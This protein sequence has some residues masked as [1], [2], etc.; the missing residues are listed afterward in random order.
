MTRMTTAGRLIATI[1][2]VVLAAP[3]QALAQSTERSPLTV[4]I[5]TVRNAEV[6]A[7]RRS[8]LPTPRLR[9]MVVVAVGKEFRMVGSHR[10]QLSWTPEVIPLLVSSRTASERLHVWECGSRQYCGSSLDSEV[11]TVQ[12]AGAGVLPL[13][14]TLG[15]RLSE[16]A[17]IR[18][19]LSGGAVMMSHPVPLAQGTHFN[20]MAEG[21]TTLEMRASR[22]VSL[23]AGMALNHISNGGLSRINLGMDSKMLEVGAVLA[24]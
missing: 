16:R 4:R 18:A 21:S 1:A 13:G 17:R 9:D 7:C 6:C 3:T 22:G 2:M 14:Y 20:F 12:A 5:G 15:V 8:D 19:R 24:R 10:V 11:F 23:T